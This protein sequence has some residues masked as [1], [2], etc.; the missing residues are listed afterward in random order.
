M[1]GDVGVE[2]SPLVPCAT[3]FIVEPWRGSTNERVS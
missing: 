1:G 2:L 3:V